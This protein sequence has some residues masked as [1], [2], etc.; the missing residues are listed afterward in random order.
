MAL[1]GIGAASSEAARQPG[2]AARLDVPSHIRLTPAFTEIVGT[3]LER[4][5]TFR[6]QWETLVTSR[7]VRITVRLDLRSRPYRAQSILSRH[8]YGLIT[9]AVELP[10]FG[11]HVELIAHEFEHIVEQLEGV[12]LRRLAHDPSAGVQD[13]HYAY[14]TERAYK[15]GR[16]VALEC[17]RHLDR[18]VKALR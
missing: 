15:V 5:P 11:D 8:Q 16:Q 9:A 10:A 7:R 14:E 13:L 6:A 18:I 2:I 1:G 3:M 12:E 4:S 17:R